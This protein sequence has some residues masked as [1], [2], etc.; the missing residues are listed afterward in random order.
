MTVSD[1]SCSTAHIAPLEDAELVSVHD[2]IDLA[3]KFSGYV[4]TSMRIMARKPALLRAFSAL[5]SAVMREPGEIPADLKWLIAHSVS[6]SAGCRYCQAHTAANSAKA[7][8]PVAKIEALMEYESSA[9]Y[10]AGERAVIAL[11]LAAGRVP[12]E[13]TRAHFDTLR[14][15]FSEGGIVEVV[16]V[17]SLFGW[18]NRWNDT[19]ASDLEQSPMEFA[20]AHLGASG[21]SPGKHG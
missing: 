8:L 6:A 11:A 12:N 14:A 15:H 19:F 13:T 9:L 2:V 21:W 17:I 1:R 3:R 20:K 4:P 10:S 18:L 7:G 5:I 16:A